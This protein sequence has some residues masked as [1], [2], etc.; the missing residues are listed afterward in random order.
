MIN[1]CYKYKI[2]NPCMKLWCIID[3]TVEECATKMVVEFMGIV[4]SRFANW[5]I[6]ASLIYR[7]HGTIPMHLQ[8]VLPC[9]DKYLIQSVRFEMHVYHVV[10]WF[11]IFVGLFI[12]FEFCTLIFKVFL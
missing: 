11:D 6:K 10:A 5:S 2:R 8:V 3:S 7:M 4:I 1:M 9:G 12:V